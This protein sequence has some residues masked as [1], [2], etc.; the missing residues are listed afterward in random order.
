MKQERIVAIDQGT[1]STR[2]FVF[3][4]RGMVLG[5]GQKEHEQ[6]FP[7]PGWV[8]HDAL[9][10]WRATQNTVAEALQAAG[11][12]PPPAAVGITNQR[13][14]LVIW[15]P[16]TGQPWLPAIV[17]QDTRTKELCEELAGDE[18]K[19]R[20]RART[21]LPLA[22]YFSGPKLRWALDHTPGLRAAAQ[23]GEVFAGTIDSWL[24]WNLTGGIQG[25]VFVTDVTN[26]SRTLLFHLEDLSWDAE[27]LAALD[28][29]ASVLPRVVS[30]SDRTPW[31]YTD[32]GGPFGVRVP[33]CAALGDQQAALLGQGCFDP[34]DAKNTYGTGCFLLAHTGTKP[35]FSRSGL[36]TT[37]AH[38]L[39]DEPACYALEGSVAIA[40]A[41][42]QWL[43]DNLGL[44]S[45]ASEIEAL[46]ASV[47]DTG[48]VYLV[49]A[50]SGLFAPHWRADARGV[51][52]GLT[53]FSTKAHIARAALEAVAHQVADVLDAMRVDTGLTLDELR[54]DGGMVQNELLCTIQANL[55][56]LELVRPAQTE[57]TALGAAYAAGL[58][59]DVFGSL[60]EL[61][62]LWTEDRRFRP[63]FDPA[64]RQRE[65]STW[66]KALER[67]LGWVE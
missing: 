24:I 9:E 44:I 28:V 59:V 20:F 61:R 26:A 41:L 3:D 60:A 36:I 22:T 45:S 46:A 64:H 67:S 25:G 66:A 30:S 19:D 56:N 32:P 33:V 15:N 49:P 65:R 42:V 7:R 34:G 21:G 11:D 38:R 5:L 54:V 6:F 35:V 27:L 37:V 50:F 16:K 4:A 2:C 12:G 13:E 39:G 58:A 63:T 8:E 29:P 23:R 40:G 47:P 55:S 52:V 43:R 48:G 31:G 51:L 18:G 10:I 53:R 14:T 17:W 57:T 1:T 62:E